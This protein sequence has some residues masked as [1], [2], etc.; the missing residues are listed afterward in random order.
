ML[1]TFFIFIYHQFDE[2]HVNHIVKLKKISQEFDLQFSKLFL[3]C[4]L[5]L[6]SS[7]FGAIA[8]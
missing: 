2:H 3:Q 7:W 6:F 8:F 4:D 1:P 5:G